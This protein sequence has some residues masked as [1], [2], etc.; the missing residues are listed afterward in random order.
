MKRRWRSVPNGRNALLRIDLLNAN[1]SAKAEGREPMTSVSNYYI[2]NDPAAWRSGVKHYGRILYRNVYPGIDLT[3]YGAGGKLE[4]DFVLGPG[5]DPNQIRMSFEGMQNLKVNADGDLV[6]TVGGAEL[7]QHR[8]VVYQQNK[9]VNG[10]F[11]LSGRQP[12]GVPGGGLR[13]EQGP[14]YRPHGVFFTP[15]WA[16]WGLTTFTLLRRMRRATWW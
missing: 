13:Q 12:G 8:P 1:A 4:Y 6:A 3:Y 9:P 7:I 15:V 5:A 16:A 11:R 2:G 10:R 14:D